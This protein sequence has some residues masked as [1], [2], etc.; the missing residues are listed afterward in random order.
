M[1]K[2]VAIVHEWLSNF[3]GSEKVTSAMVKLLPE[4]DLYSIVDFL[5]DKDRQK[6]LNG[7]HAR[8]TYIQKFPFARKNF[9]FYFPFLLHAIRA[10]NFRAYDLILTSS[11]AFAH[12]IKM[13]KNNLQI[14]YC[15]SPMRYIWSMQDL[16]FRANGFDKMIFSLL[17]K[18][19]ARYLR[20]ID[21]RTAQT[22]DY[23]IANSRF[24]A[25][26]IEKFYN[27]KSTVIYPPVDI[28]RFPLQK[29]KQE[30]Y[31]T[32]SRLVCYK[33]TDVI[34]KAF[35]KMPDKK[36]VVLGSGKYLKDLKAMATPNI[37]FIPFQ[38]FEKFN[39]YMRNA[40]AFLFAAEEDF[41]I[42]MVEA[43]A[44][45]TPVIAFDKGGANEI[46][47]DN[48]TGILFDKQ[49]DNCVVEAV[50]KFEGNYNKFEAEKIRENAIRF[51]DQRFKE[52][53]DAFIKKCLNEKS[54]KVS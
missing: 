12:S 49:E 21:Y 41:G 32:A 31:L 27:R 23:F 3:A 8:T 51:S 5:N 7:K 39:E 25:E 47:I 16:Y 19:Y 54:D 46:V 26:R 40:R 4:A 44:C 42:T 28:E 34:V 1:G 15:H 14:C 2:K 48:Q 17:P 18:I 6:M 37:T 35:T 20:K 43:Q 52:E 9:R 33:K 38:K 22:V 11:H 10:L 29:E 45:G 30:Y 24:T 36:L 50:N 53:L 13:H